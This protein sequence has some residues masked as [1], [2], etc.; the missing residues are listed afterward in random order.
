MKNIMKRAWEIAK[1]GQNNHGGKVS[2]YLSEA[3][4]M[5]WKEAKGQTDRYQLQLDNFKSA[6]EQYKE[7][8]LKA[9]EHN[10]N[11]PVIDVDVL[12]AKAT[13]QNIEGATKAM[14]IK[15]GKAK[16]YLQQK[17]NDVLKGA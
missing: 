13:P 1:W 17:R 12:M 6:L 5:A 11:T 2:E 4:K 15:I 9:K 7:L 3:L 8:S 16:V 14:Q 10:K